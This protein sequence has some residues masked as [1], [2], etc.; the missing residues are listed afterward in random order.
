MDKI[1]KV[2]P[3]CLADYG[4]RITY[5]LSILNVQ[6]ATPEQIRFF[7]Y[8]TFAIHPRELF[9]NPET[10]KKYIRF[11]KAKGDPRNL[12][13]IKVLSSQETLNQEE[14]DIP[15]KVDEEL[16]SILRR[17][18][19][20]SKNIINKGEKLFKVTSVVEPIIVS[21]IDLVS[22]KEAKMGE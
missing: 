9:H 12:N 1:F 20:E 22:Y 21:G 18:L 3:H 15:E 11:I 5:E 14:S 17:E 13:I 8:E 19:Q 6:K 2:L 10:A 16:M 4:R 7:C